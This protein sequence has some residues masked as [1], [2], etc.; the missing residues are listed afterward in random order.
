[1]D[2]NTNFSLNEE[3]FHKLLKIKKNGGFEKNTWDEWFNQVFDDVG[4]QVTR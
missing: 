2:D 3:T 1:M 4:I